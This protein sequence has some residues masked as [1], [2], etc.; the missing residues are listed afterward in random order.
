VGWVIGGLKKRKFFLVG[1]DY[2]FPR[3]ANAILRDEILSAGGEVVGEEYLLL[4]SSDVTALVKKIAES[5]PQVIL[6]TI[7]G[8]SNTAFFRA[9][10][11]A[12]ITPEKIPTVSFS[13]AEP[14]LSGV[15]RQY[16]IGDYAVW[17][18]FQS[19]KNAEN[20]S[21]VQRFKERY[22]ERRVIS[23]PMATAYVGVHLWAKAVLTAGKDETAAIRKAMRG[24]EFNAPCGLVRVDPENQHAWK[25]ARFGKITKEGQF[26][27]L[28]STENP[29]PPQPYPASR[30]REEW[31][32]MLQDYYR[33]WGNRWA[34]P[35]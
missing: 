5:K 31:E 24:Q 22:G 1:S 29:L 23:D 12:G 32:T 26:E 16:M 8:D 30:K 21:F 17:N 27:I 13:V 2:I 14:E 19:I 33:R 20:Q 25:V 9:L 28:F 10:R 34:N 3:M 35:G 7:N 18:Y 15:G 6:N 11:Q 4:G